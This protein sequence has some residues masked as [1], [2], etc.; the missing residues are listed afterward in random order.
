MT[1][2]ERF[3]LL[4]RQGKVSDSTLT[5]MAGVK[6][7]FSRVINA[8]KPSRHIKGIEQTTPRAGMDFLPAVLLAGAIGTAPAVAGK[9]EDAYNSWKLDKSKEPS[10][11]A[12]L[13]YHPQLKDQDME[14]VRRYFD[15][16]WHFSPHLAQDPLAAGAY[17]RHALQY[18]DAVGG[19]GFNLIGDLTQVQKNVS[20]SKEKSRGYVDLNRFPMPDLYAGS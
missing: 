2:E 9:V 10:F 13:E 19:P 5:K 20:T 4:H 17:I 16:A 6:D 18:Q 15:S 3:Y 11:N 1:N 12:M 14:L 7:M 8:F